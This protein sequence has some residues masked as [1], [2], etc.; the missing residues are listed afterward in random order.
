MQLGR[1]DEAAEKF[2]QM[3]DRMPNRTQSLLGAARVAVKRGDLPKAKR[4]YSE[5]LRIW[6]ENSQSGALEEAR[7][8]LRASEGSGPR[9]RRV[10]LSNLQGR[11][12]EKKINT[13]QLGKGSRLGVS[14]LRGKENVPQ[15]PVTRR[16]QLPEQG[17]VEEVRRSIEAQAAR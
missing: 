12:S 17:L 3:L 5:L 13:Q 1:L 4:R 6:D 7:E 11:I 9:L 15:P 14:R 16:E 2:D 8:F 10:A